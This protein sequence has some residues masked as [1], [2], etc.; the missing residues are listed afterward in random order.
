MKYSM[1]GIVSLGI[2][3]MLL[4]TSLPAGAEREWSEDCECGCAPDINGHNDYQRYNGSQ[5]SGDWMNGWWGWYPN[6]MNDSDIGISLT[7]IWG[8]DHT[9]IDEFRFD[10]FINVTVGSYPPPVPDYTI[11]VEDGNPP[12]ETNEIYYPDEVPILEYGETAQINVTIQMNN[13]HFFTAI[14]LEIYVDI[15]QYTAQQGWQD[16]LIRDWYF[17]WAMPLIP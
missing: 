17:R 7:I 12:Q 3:I 2:L 16:Y 9:Q 5:Y 15:D 8:N 6:D 10:Y 14:A 11:Y 4:A 13:I 1:A